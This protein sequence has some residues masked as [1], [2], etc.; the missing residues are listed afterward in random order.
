MLKVFVPEERKFFVTW[1]TNTGQT[2]LCY[3]GATG[4]EVPNSKVEGGGGLYIGIAVS[5]A[6]LILCTVS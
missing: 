2:K 1:H 4:E 6:E 5:A 3:V